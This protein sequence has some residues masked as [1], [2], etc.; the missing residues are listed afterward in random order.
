MNQK[1]ARTVKDKA[2]QW[3]RRALRAR[4]RD[5]QEK[6]ETCILISCILGFLLIVAIS[7][8]FVI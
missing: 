2:E 3:A 5:I 4:D 6:Y 1:M 8:I 7:L